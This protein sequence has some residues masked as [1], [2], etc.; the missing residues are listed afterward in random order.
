MTKQDM[1]QI[2][3]VCVSTLK[4]LNGCMPGV[5]ELCSALGEE[6]AEILTEYMDEY[7]IAACAA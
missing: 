6:Y 5:E 7:K 3:M 1:K 4:N 2:L